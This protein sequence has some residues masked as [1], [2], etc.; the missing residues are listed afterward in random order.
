HAMKPLH[1]VIRQAEFLRCVRMILL[2]PSRMAVCRVR[3]RE[4]GEALEF[5]LDHWTLSEATPNGQDLPPLSDWGVITKDFDQAMSPQALLKRVQPKSSQSVV[6]ICLQAENPNAFPTLVFD[7]GTWRTPESI[8]FVGAGMLTLPDVF[9][10][11]AVTLRES[12]TAGALGPLFPRLKASSIALIGAGRGGQELA[13]QFVAAGLRRLTVVDADRLAI[14]NLDAMP[15]ARVADLDC[16]KGE[17]L[18]AALR[19]NQPDATISW[20]PRSIWHPESLRKLRETRVDAVFSFVDRDAARL[21][22][23]RLCQETTTVHIDIGTNVQRN[24]DGSRSMTAD[25]RLFEPHEGCVACVPPMDDLSDVL[26]EIATPE[27]CLHRGVP[28][29]WH[30]QRAGSLL[31]LNSFACAIAIETWFAWLAGKLPTSHWVRVEWPEFGLPEVRAGSVGP[32]QDCSF[33]K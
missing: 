22:A 21:T 18:A 11:S 13:R 28:V 2:D 8:R 20:T 7:Q 19:Q 30:E 12:R 1:L 10:D 6:G 23:A 25:I 16:N 4:T 17:Q 9:D 29:A 27:D 3:R 26:Y 32:R 33:C 14:E 15:L 31:Y 24:A 5:L